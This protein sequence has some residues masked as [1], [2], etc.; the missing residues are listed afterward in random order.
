M[1]GS[2]SEGKR[3]FFNVDPSR[4]HSLIVNTIRNNGRPFY[5]EITIK[6]FA[7]KVQNVSISESIDLSILEGN[8][9]NVQ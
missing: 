2:K 3:K 5:G 9:A 1:S 4:L 6:V 8:D 7:N